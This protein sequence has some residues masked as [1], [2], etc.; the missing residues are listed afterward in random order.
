MDPQLEYSFARH[1]F[2]LEAISEKKSMELYHLIVE[3]DEGFHN[4][5]KILRALEHSDPTWQ[6]SC[7]FT[8]LHW[9]ATLNRV[10]LACML[11]EH[12]YNPLTL[13]NNGDTPFDI[14]RENG[15]DEVAG[16]IEHFRSGAPAL[17][18]EPT[19]FKHVDKAF[20]EK[21]RAWPVPDTLEEALAMLMTTPGIEDA[22]RN[23]RVDFRDRVSAEGDEGGEADIEFDSD[24]EIDVVNQGG[25][26]NIT[27]DATDTM[28]NPYGLSENQACA[29]SVF[30]SN[31][32]RTRINVG[33]ASEDGEKFTPFARLLN[34]ALL[35][36][37]PLQGVVY[38]TVAQPPPFGMFRVGTKFSWGGFVLS[39]MYGNSIE[40][41]LKETQSTRRACTVF[42]INAISARPI[43]SYSILRKR[44]TEYPFEHDMILPFASTF[45]VENQ[46]S[47]N[48]Y[49]TLVAL[50]EISSG[51]SA[52]DTF[53][54]SGSIPKRPLLPATETDTM[55]QRQSN[56]PEQLALNKQKKRITLDSFHDQHDQ[57]YE[58]FFSSS[59]SSVSE[60]DSEADWT[61]DWDGPVTYDPLVESEDVDEEEEE[62][63]EEEKNKRSLK[64]AISSVGDAN[65]VKT[66]TRKTRH[67]K[68]LENPP[69]AIVF[70]M[71]YMANKY[72]RNKKMALKIKKKAQKLAKK[73][74]K[75]L[76][77]AEKLRKHNEAM[78]KYEEEMERRAHQLELYQI[79]KDNHKK[80][81][82]KHK[83]RTQHDFK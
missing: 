32:V 55:S 66:I 13:D 65:A 63:E 19:F 16:V 39:S 54:M 36:I 64:D 15:H 61:V 37:P 80:A 30:T 42:H 58:H 25:A 4:T 69:K 67:Q 38:C 33:F 6:D 43:K 79:K 70:L 77:K 10:D 72:A 78:K 1:T 75:K 53:D 18:I 51:S 20:M 81:R 59:G 47:I 27:F 9:A 40:D 5:E 83:T 35:A 7:G 3:E 62:E 76:K 41:F 29:I 71:N 52:V 46:V 14:A 49:V 23:A 34:D 31:C 28:H 11:L 44:Y 45:R 73:R 56:T 17:G 57:D 74:V 68:A 24:D 50:T 82:K 26:F 2:S 60:F 48:S 22:V 12:G 8:L 21:F